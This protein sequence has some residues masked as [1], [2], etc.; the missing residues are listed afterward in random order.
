MRDITTIGAGGGTLARV[1][2]I[3]NL[4]IVGPESAGAVPGPVCFNRGG[5]IP[6][7]TDA[8]VVM[9]RIN[10]EYFLKGRFK[11]NR[12]KA[13]KAIK[14]KIAEPLRMDV[15]TAAEGICKVLDA[16]MGSTIRAALATK[17]GDISQ[18]AL[19]VYGGAGP[20]HC[21]GFTAGMHFKEIIIPP[22]AA[23]FSAFGAATADITHR[24]EA[25]PFVTI[26]GIPYDPTTLRFNLDEVRSLDDLR[27]EGIERFNRI[28]REL[29]E[30]ARADMHAEGLREENVFFNYEILGRYGGQLW[31]L[32]VRIP[33]NRINS[34]MDLKLVV[35]SFEDRYYDE[36]GL[37]AMAPRG[38]VQI[39]TITVE[40]VGRIE[41]PMFTEGEY[42][43]ENPEKAFKEERKIYFNGGFKQCKIYS[44]D[45]LLPGNVIHGSSIIEGIDTTVV[46][47]ED[48][49]IF[50]D[51]Y[52][53]M[54]MRY[55]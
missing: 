24:Y 22:F 15:M 29:E 30:R 26:R 50:V 53:N 38:G 2:K 37:Q 48:R 13:V 55:R 4:L 31:E 33:I 51:R 32:R 12:E 27:H 19:V 47:P 1:E 49:Q 23:V 18:Y 10:S 21:A 52:R 16:K 42:M 25:S 9:N 28:F 7:I 17:G 35:K 40:L 41:K 3:A 8:D 20:T 11:L 5:E 46:I 36:Y 45:N 39:I 14:E 34:V 6:T 43:G 54:L 44:M